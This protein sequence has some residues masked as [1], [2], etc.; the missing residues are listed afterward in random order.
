M[1]GLSTAT[2]HLVSL[3]GSPTD[4]AALRLLRVGQSDEPPVTESPN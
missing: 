4:A 1:H 2:A 3:L